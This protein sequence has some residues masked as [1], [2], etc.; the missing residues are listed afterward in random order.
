MIVILVGF[1]AISWL[2]TITRL[3][4]YRRHIVWYG[5]GMVEYRINNWN[6]RSE[7][8]S[9]AL[10]TRDEIIE[11]IEAI[12]DRDFGGFIAESCDV[13]HGIVMTLALLVFGSWMRIRP[14]Y[15]VFYI[16]CPLTAWKHGER[17]RQYQCVRSLGHH[18]SKGHASN[19]V[20]GDAEKIGELRAALMNI[21]NQTIDEIVVEV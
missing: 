11:V 5:R 19:H 20:C 4:I 21:K 13:W 15:W 12:A 7:A 6:G 18:D 2:I 16:L 8:M 1:I 9:M 17:Y 14:L 3:I 10:A